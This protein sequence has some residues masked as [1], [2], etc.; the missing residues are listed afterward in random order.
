MTTA[1]DEITAAAQASAERYRGPRM[2]VGTLSDREYVAHVEGW[3][4]CREYL[5]A[6]TAATAQDALLTVVPDDVRDHWDRSEDNRERFGDVG[7]VC[8]LCRTI[9]TARGD[10]SETLPP[11]DL[12]GPNNNTERG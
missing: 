4:A 7:C 9:Q 10:K 2:N 12:L 5:A 1:A 6:Q 3:A 11:L 8:Y